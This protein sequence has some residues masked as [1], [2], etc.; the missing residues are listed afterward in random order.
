MPKYLQ[1]KCMDNFCGLSHKILYRNIKS[2]LKN[3]SFC[4]V[5]CF[6]RIH[7]YV[8]HILGG[9]CLWRTQNNLFHSSVIK[10]FVELTRGTGQRALRRRNAVAPCVCVNRVISHASSESRGQQRNRTYTPKDV[11]FRSKMCNNSH[12][13]RSTYYACSRPARGIYDAFCIAA[14]IRA[15]QSKIL[16]HSIRLAIF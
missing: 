12:L 6:S 5:A 9:A 16:L 3:Y 4:I 7:Y 15:K 1:V 14:A 2:Y 13:S 11:A 8:I 10:R